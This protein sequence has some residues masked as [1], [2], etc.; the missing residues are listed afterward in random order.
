MYQLLANPRN[1]SELLSM[2]KRLS[3]GAFIP[4]DAEN[5]D[6]Q[7]YLKWLAQGNAPLPPDA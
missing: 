4:F 7:Q 3:D 2:V 6:Y 5:S 1:P